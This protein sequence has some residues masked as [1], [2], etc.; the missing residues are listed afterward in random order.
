MDLKITEQTS[1]DLDKKIW[2][3]GIGLS[4]WLVGLCNRTNLDSDSAA[5]RQMRDALFSSERR[6]IL[7]L[8]AGTGLVAIAIAALRSASNLPD[9]I[10]ATD[11][12]SAMPLLEQNISSN[13]HTFTTSPK[14]VVLDWD[15]ED[16]PQDVTGLEDGLD[17]IVMADVTYNTASFPSLIR[18]LDKLLRLGSKPSAILLGYKERDAAER[19]LW[20]MAAEIGVEFEKVGERAGA[21]GAPVEIWIGHLRE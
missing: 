5:V 3:S 19:T 6:T 21:G 9:D 11:V 8:G 20:D 1:F 10:I 18:T 12:S 15:D 13:Q 14:A 4:S 7:E 2:D 16:F 17:A